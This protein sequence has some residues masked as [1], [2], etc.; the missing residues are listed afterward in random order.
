[1][2]VLCGCCDQPIIDHITQGWG[3]P[4]GEAHTHTQ[5]TQAHTQ[6]ILSACCWS[7]LVLSYDRLKTAV[8]PAVHCTSVPFL[9]LIIP[10]YMNPTGFIWWILNFQLQLYS[11]RLGQWPATYV[12]ASFPGHVCSIVTLGRKQ[13]L[14][15]IAWVIVS[16]RNWVPQNLGNSFTLVKHL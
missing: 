7:L 11:H 15:S 8:I 1:M 12:L 2:I 10:N 14:V 3:T 13:G 9:T 6:K 16:M 4:K 5:Q